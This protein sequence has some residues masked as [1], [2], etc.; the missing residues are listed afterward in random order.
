MPDTTSDRIQQIVAS[1]VAEEGLD[2]VEIQLPRFK[3]RQMVRIFI[4]KDSGVTLDDCRLIS[5]KVAER[6][7]I[8]DLFASRYVLEVSS[9]GLDRPLKTARDFKRNMGRSVCLVTKDVEGEN[10]SVT[11]VVRQV[12]EEAITI[13]TSGGTE[14][15]FLHSIVQG[16]VCIS[17]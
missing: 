15:F 2:V 5:R 12:T 7:E 14:D 10:R 16:K 8:E 4:D 11:G 3:T 9:P 6:L 1:V 13:E 17:I